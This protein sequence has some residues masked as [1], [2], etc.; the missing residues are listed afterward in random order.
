[1]RVLRAAGVRNAASSASTQFLCEEKRMLCLI[2]GN[3]QLSQQ[4]WGEVHHL[5]C[6]TKAI[7]SIFLTKCQV[8]L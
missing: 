3:P 5:S 8:P 2:A 4:I 7:A 1:M 6:D